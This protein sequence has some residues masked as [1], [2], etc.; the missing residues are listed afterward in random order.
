MLSDKDREEIKEIIQLTVNGKIDKLHV[1]VDGQRDDLN[2]FIAKLDP[3]IDAMGWLN[4]T[5]R[6][7]TWVGG[8]AGSIAAVFALQNYFN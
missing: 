6:A 5:K 2:L 1:K 7:V 3:V 4:T 8:L